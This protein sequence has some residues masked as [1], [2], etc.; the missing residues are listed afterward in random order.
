MKR[1]RGRKS[2]YEAAAYLPVMMIYKFHFQRLLRR[3]SKP[4]ISY[5][6]FQLFLSLS[7][8]SH[9]WFHVAKANHITYGFTNFNS[10]NLVNKY[11]S[12]NP[13]TSKSLFRCVLALL[14]WV[15]S[16]RRSAVRLVDLF[17]T[18]MF[19]LQSP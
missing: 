14:Q 16:V 3:F 4:D 18:Q 7:E 1:R 17:V 6:G 13:R 11:M 19:R 2:G 5:L 15:M 9:I 12:V 8:T 10:I